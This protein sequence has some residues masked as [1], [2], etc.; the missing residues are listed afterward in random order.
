[1]SDGWIKIFYRFTEW[2]WYSDTNMVRLFLHLLLRA[3]YKPV[4]CRGE[5][6]PRGALVT[7]VD[8]LHHETGLSVQQI[9]TCLKRLIS[10]NEITNRTTKHGSII[11]VCNYDRYQ[12][13][14]PEA[15]KQVNKPS[16]NQL[17]NNQQ[18]ANKQLTTCIERK[19]GRKEEI[20]NIST[21]DEVRDKPSAAGAAPPSA[22]RKVGE[23]VLFESILDD[24]NATCRGYPAL[25]V[26]SESRKAKIR[27]RIAEMGGEEKAGPLVHQL[28]EKL[29]ASPFLR[30]ENARGWKA[31]FDWLFENDKNWVKV[32]EGQYDQP[33]IPITTKPQRNATTTPLQ[34]DADARRAECLESIA[35]DLAGYNDIEP[36][37]AD[38][39]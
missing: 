24:W 11:T 18:T 20:K 17:T 31:S 7:S 1:M 3:N 25:R 37:V 36:D 29:A 39:L 12:D 8:K 33:L 35:L 38:R 6:I 14:F 9:R 2:E 32:Y 5:T 21:S 27:S 26:L 15:N 34:S 19:K 30:G 10:T 4:K 23:K 28:F 22:P 13:D 16:N